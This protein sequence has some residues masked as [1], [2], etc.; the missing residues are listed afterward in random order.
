MSRRADQQNQPQDG[1]L[2]SEIWQALYDFV[3]AEHEVRLESAEARGVSPGDLKALM[4]LV[5]GRGESMRTLAGTWRCDASTVTWIVD[6]LE[7]RGLVERQPHPSDRRVKL[8][9]LSRK[10]ERLRDE[11]LGGLYRPPAVLS[12]LPPDDLRTLHR[13]AT[14]LQASEPD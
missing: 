10:G 4:R 9:V 12:A 1:Q 5:P 13:L 7:T 2:E 6:R 8:V 3:L 11:L 14:R